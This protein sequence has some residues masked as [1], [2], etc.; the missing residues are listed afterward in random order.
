MSTNPI[1]IP[2]RH[3]AT[4]PVIDP[5]LCRG[6]PPHDRAAAEQQLKVR[7]ATVPRGPWT[8]PAQP[9]LG[10]PAGLLVVDGFL[11]RTLR[12]D[13][14]DA[15]ELLAAGDLIRPWQED[16]ASFCTS[17]WRVI[18]ECRVAIIDNRVLAAL[19]TW[20]QVTTELLA[21][22]L[23]RSRWLAVQAAISAMVGV[24][25]KLLALLWHIAE[26]WGHTDPDGAV[27]I[28]VPLTHELLAEMMGVGRTYVTHGIS[29]LTRAGEVSRR[30]DRAFALH[31]APPDVAAEGSSR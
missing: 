31:G 23:N 5:Q 16:A 4:L 30:P 11:T 19:A 1:E 2:T 18:E 25:N 28:D 3:R 13:S 20:P 14:S 29:R 12:L 22:A 15:V 24:E 6:I 17:S 9:P 26:R 27:L 8:P 10:A 7:V 21:R